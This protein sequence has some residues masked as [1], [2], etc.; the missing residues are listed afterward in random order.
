MGKISSSGLIVGVGLPLCEVF[1]IRPNIHNSLT[2]RVYDYLNDFQ[3]IIPWQ[4]QVQFPNLT[5]IVENIVIPLE[6]KQVKLMWTNSKSG[7]VS[8]KDAYQL[9]SHTMQKI[10]WATTIWSIDIPPSRSFVAWR[11][12]HDRMPIDEKL[13]ERDCKFPSICTLCLSQEETTFHLFFACPY[14]MRI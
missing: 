2:S 8:L 12:M 7:D 6:H 9:K 1:H 10:H 13:K 11:I 3:W 14:A 5:Q 4:L